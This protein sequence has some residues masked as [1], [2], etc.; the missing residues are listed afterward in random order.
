MVSANRLRMEEK[1]LMIEISCTD[2]RNL[3]AKYLKIDN[4]YEVANLIVGQMQ[5]TEIGVSQLFKSLL[6]IFPTLEY[7]IGDFVWINIANLGSWRMD[8]VKTS[9]LPTCREDMLLCKIVETNVYRGSP[10]KVVFD[11]IR[12]KET[13]IK[14]DMSDVSASA[15][16]EKAEHYLDILELLEKL[17]ED[18]DLPF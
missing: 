4:S 2:L 16:R 13:D 12:D 6:G 10:Y 5:L 9:T 3:L 1:K 17:K 18:A 14:T 11:I 7:K 8:K 15:I